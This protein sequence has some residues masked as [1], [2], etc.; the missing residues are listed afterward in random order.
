MI[1][2][3]NGAKKRREEGNEERRGRAV[4]DGLRDLIALGSASP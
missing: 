3:K 2:A 1:G 4:G